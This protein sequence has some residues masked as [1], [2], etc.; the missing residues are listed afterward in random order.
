MW[1]EIDRSRTQVID[2]KRGSEPTVAMAIDPLFGVRSRPVVDS[3][4]E[5][6]VRHHRR[7]MG[8]AAPV[9]LDRA[10]AD[11]IV[12][13]AFA[14]LA[15]RIE[16]VRD[17]GAYLQRSVINLAIQVVRKREQA[18]SIP[19]RPLERSTIPTWMN[20]GTSLLT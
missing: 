14:G 19:A 4:G 11:E 16:A 5:L 20:S 12:Q 18:R 8:L 10:V 13:E 9:T 15:S 6:F 3:I 7:L 2:V 17:P 1:N